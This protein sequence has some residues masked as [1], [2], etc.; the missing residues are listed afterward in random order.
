MPFPKLWRCC[1]IVIYVKIGYHTVRKEKPDKKNWIAGFSAKKKKRIAKSFRLEWTVHRLTEV[2]IPW[3]EREKEDNGEFKKARSHP[4]EREVETSVKRTDRWLRGLLDVKKSD[5][6]LI[7]RPR[8]DPGL[9]QH[10]SSCLSFPPY[11]SVTQASVRA[12]LL[13][14]RCTEDAGQSP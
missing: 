11:P 9:S 3:K 13:C 4:A 5:S 1:H 6:P 12:S 2:K 14:R 8:N 10:R 7:L